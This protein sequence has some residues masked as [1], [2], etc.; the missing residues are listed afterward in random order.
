MGFARAQPI[1]RALTI[2]RLLEAMRRVI[3]LRSDRETEMSKHDQRQYRLMLGQLT[4]FEEGQIRLDTLVDDLVGL[5][6]ALDGVSNSWKQ[7]F[8]HEWGKLEDERA[9]ALYEN[10]QILDQ[11]TSQRIRLAVSKL[12]LIVLEN[13]LP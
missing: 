1:L 9:Y 6:N 2:C 8:L 5:L 7:T 13:T 11:E 10:L 3:S 4:K 12:K